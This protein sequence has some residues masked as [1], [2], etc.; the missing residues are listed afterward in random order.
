MHLIIAITGSP[1]GPVRHLIL[2]T[3]IT[4]T[5]LTIMWDASS[6]FPDR[7]EVVY[8]YIVKRCL[9]TGGPLTANISDLSMM[10]YTHNLSNLNEDSSYTI[11][12]T[13]INTAGSSMVE[14]VTGN[15]S[16]AGELLRRSSFREKH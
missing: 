4:A 2:T 10:S 13:A 6:G 8:R 3:P 1:P 11:S 15:T 14:T 9:A 12:V 16:T 7:Y 5:T